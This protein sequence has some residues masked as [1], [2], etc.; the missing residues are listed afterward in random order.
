MG[1]V[2]LPEAIFHANHT[3][4]YS[5]SIRAVSGETTP[6]RFRDLSTA[7]NCVSHGLDRR[8][9][10]YRY[11]VSLGLLV[12]CPFGQSDTAKHPPLPEALS[13][14]DIPTPTPGWMAPAEQAHHSRAKDAHIM[15]REWEEST[16]MTDHLVCHASRWMVAF[17]G[18]FLDKTVAKLALET[19]QT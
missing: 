17:H 11:A 3:V 13:A 14:D 15:A 8:S 18:S 10:V 1:F 16:L 7:E 6:T 5:V 2:S 19:V 12:Y 4:R 9:S